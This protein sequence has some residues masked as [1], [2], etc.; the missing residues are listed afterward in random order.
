LGPMDTVI[1]SKFIKTLEVAE[2]PP[3]GPEQAQLH[4]R[5]SD[6]PPS[7]MF[8]TGTELMYGGQG[9]TTNNFNL[10]PVNAQRN[11]ETSAIKLLDKV[12]NTNEGLDQPRLDETNAEVTGEDKRKL[13]TQNKR[14][15]QRLRAAQ[16]PQSQWTTHTGQV[17]Y[18]STPLP[19]ARGT[20]RNSMCPTGSPQQGKASCLF[21]SKPSQ[22]SKTN[23]WEN[24]SSNGSIRH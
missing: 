17:D 18:D 12:T 10:T 13:R 14:R 24:G 7:D 4:E 11:D 19:R 5:E 22:R 2:G 8:K 9:K 21:Q 6:R 1:M 15:K 20:Y 3:T 23:T 16:V